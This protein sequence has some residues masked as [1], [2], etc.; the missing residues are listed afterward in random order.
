MINIMIGNV[1][2]Y[3]DSVIFN[4]RVQSKKKTD[5]TINLPRQLCWVWCGIGVW[6]IILQVVADMND[7]DDHDSNA[8]LEIIQWLL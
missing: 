6:Y 4:C 5:M 8:G 3:N 7:F 2:V 1:L